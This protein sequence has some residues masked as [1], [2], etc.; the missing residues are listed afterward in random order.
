V[1]AATPAP[2]V[3]GDATLR[4]LTAGDLP[5]TIAWRNH[6]ESRGWFHTTHEISA[7]E[8]SEWFRRYLERDDD[9]VLIL[10]IAGAPVAQVSVYDVN[11][12]VAEFGRLLV[13]P[14]ARGRGISHRAIALCLR[15][16]VE[17]LGLRELRLEVKTDN[18]RAIR[19]YEAAEFRV[20]E[21]RVRNDGFQVMVRDIP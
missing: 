2:I 10:E 3:D 17:V 12:G 20:D 16:A 19:A 18:V 9:Y 6:P 21:A 8:H 4:M 11:N 5:A 1:T 7:V 15:F 14:V 13:D